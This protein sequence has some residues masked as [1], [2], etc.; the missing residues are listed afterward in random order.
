MLELA[1]GVCVDGVEDIPR[2]TTKAWISCRKTLN[3]TYD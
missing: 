3:E 1:G 2:A